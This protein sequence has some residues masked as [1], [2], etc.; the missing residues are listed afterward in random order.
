[1]TVGS[2]QPAHGPQRARR[3][4]IDW[5]STGPS[6]TASRFTWNP[7]I[8]WLHGI[9]E[10]P[11]SGGEIGAKA[12]VSLIAQLTQRAGAAGAV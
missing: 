5:L 6:E 12:R 11:R 9:V 1:M 10:G 8:A 3:D 2:R 7:G 4:R